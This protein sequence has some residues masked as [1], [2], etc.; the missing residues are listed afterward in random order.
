MK[1]GEAAAVTDLSMRSK[2]HW[3]YDKAFLDACLEELTVARDAPADRLAVA[4]HEGSV[5]G[6]VEISVEGDSAL[7]ERIF[8][9]PDAMG[10]GFGRTLM[11][12]AKSAARAAG[13]STLVVESDPN[14][15]PFYRRM[16][17]IDAGS[18][19]SRSI[20]GRVLPRLI[21]PLTD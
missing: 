21:I 6:V 17:A 15:V 7:L 5:V 8:V 14:S 9:E 4:E 10:H 1:P 2:A 11:S 3:G 20:E 16:G 19:P 13:A 18:V 12:W